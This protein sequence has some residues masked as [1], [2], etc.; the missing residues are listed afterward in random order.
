MLRNIGAT[1]RNCHSWSAH[2]A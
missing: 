1:M 2:H